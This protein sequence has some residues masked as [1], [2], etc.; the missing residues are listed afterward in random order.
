VK[1]LGAVL[2]PYEV[3]GIG[4]DA[5]PDELRAA[6]RSL[7]RE[8]HPDRF[9]SATEDERRAMHER[10]ASINAAYRMVRDPGELE[11][12]RRLQARRPGAGARN[13]VRR[14]GV[15][16]A[17]RASAAGGAGPAG[18]PGFDYRHR[19]ASEFRVRADVGIRVGPWASKR[20]ARRRGKRR[21]FRRWAGR[22]SGP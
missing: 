13:Q 22:R 8:H 14:D 17:A 7:V 2:D 6:Y 20:K 9:P 15:S 18:D 11:R 12:L 16:S 19:A 3:L 4:A 10:M 1:G 21:W 5:T